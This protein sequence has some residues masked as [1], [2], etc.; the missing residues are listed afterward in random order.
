[1]KAQIPE[2]NFMAKFMNFEDAEFY[3]IEDFY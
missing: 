3:K 1:M 2:P